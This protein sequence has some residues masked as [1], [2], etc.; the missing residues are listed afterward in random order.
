MIRLH[1]TRSQQ[2][3][4]AFGDGVPDIKFQLTRFIATHGK[5]GA[6]IAFGPDVR[7]LQRFAQI[8]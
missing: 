6:V 5:P 2:S 8:G 3:I 7:A 4:G 1:G